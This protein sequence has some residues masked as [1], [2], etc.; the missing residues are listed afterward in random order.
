MQ[1]MMAM[2]VEAY[3]KEKKDFE[4]N[5]DKANTSLLEEGMAKKKK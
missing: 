5:L 4:H 2:A 1:K 3:R